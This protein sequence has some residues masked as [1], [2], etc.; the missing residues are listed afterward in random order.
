MQYSQP[1][2]LEAEVE[3][4]CNLTTSLAYHWS[5]SGHVNKYANEM[6]RK[7]LILPAR[8]L[9]LGNHTIIFKVFA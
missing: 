8:S 1:F 5:I 2:K 3:T 7:V 4:N 6:Y 9:D